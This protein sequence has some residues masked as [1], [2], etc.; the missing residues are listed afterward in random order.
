MV[1]KLLSNTFFVLKSSD[2][3]NQLKGKRSKSE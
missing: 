1:V 3:V 2:K